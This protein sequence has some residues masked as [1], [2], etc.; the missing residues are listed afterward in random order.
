LRET[1]YEL[2]LYHTTLA[3]VSVVVLAIAVI[4]LAKVQPS[5]SAATTLPRYIDE[6]DVPT[7]HSAPLALTV[8][9]NGIVWFTE[10]NATKL[11]RFDPGTGTFREYPVPGIGDMWGITTDMSGDIWLTQY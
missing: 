1:K 10:S 11:G 4:S 2:G 6:Y 3:R 9:R 8:D 5:V 7:P